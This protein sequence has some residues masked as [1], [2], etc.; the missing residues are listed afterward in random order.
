[1]AAAAGAAAAA[2]PTAERGLLGGAVRGEY[3]ELP[4]DLR[5]LT[6]GAADR[7]AVPHELLE[8][9]L[10]LHA[11]VL[12]DRHGRNLAQH[13]QGV[14]AV[15]PRRFAGERLPARRFW[16]GRSRRQTSNSVTVP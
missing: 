9:R 2:A 1:M 8:V 11:H 12:V 13:R 15:V 10:A 3:R 6:V 7:L 5:R 4:L 14:L 16:P